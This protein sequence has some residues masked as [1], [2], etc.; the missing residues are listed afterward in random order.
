MKTE[1]SPDYSAVHGITFMFVWNVE[2]VSLSFR[3]CIHVN[4]CYLALPLLTGSGDS[5]DNRLIA[6]Y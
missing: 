6:L 2:D 5:D 4:L 1:D 3:M